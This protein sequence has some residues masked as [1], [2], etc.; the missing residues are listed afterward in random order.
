MESSQAVTIHRPSGLKT[1][2]RIAF[3]PSPT[4]KTCSPVAAFQTRA[5]PSSAA[6]TTHFPSGLKAAS[7]TRP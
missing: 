3:R 5:V 7:L 6:V 4:M 2:E 1:A